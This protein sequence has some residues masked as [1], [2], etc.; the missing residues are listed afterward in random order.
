V[1]YKLNWL[2]VLT[3]IAIILV[4]GCATT[5]TPKWK[6]TAYGSWTF[7]HAEL[8]KLPIISIRHI[9]SSG[10]DTEHEKVINL[11]RARG[12]DG[13]AE[14][15]RIAAQGE[16]IVIDANDKQQEKIKIA[17]ITQIQRIRK[18]KV[19]PAQNKTGS[20]AEGLVYLPL[21]PFAIVSR[22]FLGVMGLDANKNSTD[23][24][25]AML[26]YGGM[27]KKELITYIGEPVEKYFCKSKQK[28]NIEIWVY[29]KSQVLRGGRTLFI[30]LA[31]DK[32]YHTSADT[33]FFK[34]SATLN[35]SV[36]TK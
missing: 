2:S 19:A 32:V 23:A 10:S 28:S 6:K 34:S 18:I 12:L 25:K 21:I 16:V 27:S 8:E 13:V 5:N 1:L 9:L 17:Q 15:K 20:V 26:A 3:L 22:P 4:S 29:D 11:V 31:D 14:V 24:A 33:T 30:N 7:S 36:L 35:C